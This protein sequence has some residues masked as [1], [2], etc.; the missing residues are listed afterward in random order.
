VKKSEGRGVEDRCNLKKA[1]NAARLTCYVTTSETQCNTI[2]YVTEPHL[3]FLQRIFDVT[4]AAA[5]WKGAFLD[6]G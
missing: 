4:R 5:W 1:I 6:Q 2:F 3:I